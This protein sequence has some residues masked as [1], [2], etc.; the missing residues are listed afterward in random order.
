MA[1]SWALRMDQVTRPPKQI[2]IIAMIMIVILFIMTLY[3]GVAENRKGAGNNHISQA[4]R[5]IT[6]LP[7]DLGVLF[8]HLGHQYDP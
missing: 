1:D 7:C 5:G 3:H 2:T 8:V 4:G 6:P